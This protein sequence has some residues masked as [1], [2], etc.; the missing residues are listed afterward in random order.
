MRIFFVFLFALLVAGYS[1]GAFARGGGG[2]SSGRNSYSRSAS[3]GRVNVSGYTRKNGTYVA[4]H[5]R[6]APNRTTSDNWSHR[7]NVNPNTGKVGTKDD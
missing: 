2:Y 4:P 6:T 5:Q 3:D 1:D 7:G